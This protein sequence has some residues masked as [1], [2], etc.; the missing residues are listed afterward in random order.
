MLLRRLGLT[1][2]AHGADGEAPLAQV[3]P[4]ATSA[5]LGDHADPAEMVDF[6]GLV[7]GTPFET[8]SVVTESRLQIDEWAAAAV[9]SVTSRALVPETGPDLVSG[10]PC[11]HPRRSGRTQKQRTCRAGRG[12]PPLR[13][14]RPRASATPISCG[15][16][17]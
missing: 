3:T 17:R 13:G 9:A 16:T 14:R 8:E 10:R 4:V 2:K 7:F 12:G 11:R 1:L 5:T 6:A 15:P